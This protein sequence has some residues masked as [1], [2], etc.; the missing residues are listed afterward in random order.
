[1]KKLQVLF[2]VCIAF[3]F[4]FNV[5]GQLQTTFRVG[6]AIPVGDFGSVEITNEG[7]SGAT[8]GFSAGVG[9]RVP[10]GSIGIGVFGDLDL[11]YNAQDQD[12]EEDFEE[13]MVGMTTGEVDATHVMYFNLPVSIGV[14]YQ[15]KISDRLSLFGR[16]GAVY[17]TFLITPYEITIDGDIEASGTYMPSGNQGVRFGFGGVLKEMVTVAFDY[18]ALG[19]HTIEGTMVNSLGTETDIEIKRKVDMVTVTF[20]VRF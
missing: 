1:M 14:D 11:H 20:G 13:L 17:N 5:H 16:A 12:Y 19:E 8:T 3:C 2:I 10:L 18:W 15:H 7:A 6:P 4:S 9:V